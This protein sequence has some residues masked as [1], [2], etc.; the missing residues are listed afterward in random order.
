MSIP[1]LPQERNRRSSPRKVLRQEATVVHGDATKQAQTCDVGADG[2]SLLAARPIA[3]GTRCKATFVVPVGNE[4]VQV[5]VALKVVYSSY[6]ANGEFKIGAVF[7][8]LDG[9]AAA[10]L[11]RFV[12]DS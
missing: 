8:D 10:V 1:P 3:P 7:T 11:G 2:M 6:S 5:T 4:T 12:A 9:E